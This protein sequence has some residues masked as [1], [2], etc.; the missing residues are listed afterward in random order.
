VKVQIRF[1]HFWPGFEPEKSFF[2]AYVRNREF[3]PILCQKKNRDVDLEIQSVFPGL[4]KRAELKLKNVIRPSVYGVDTSLNRYF[5]HTKYKKH[6]K[7]LIW[8]SGENV[9]T[10]IDDD[11]DLTL[12]YEEDTYGGKNIYFPLWFTS[13]NLM[14]EVIFNARAGIEV[15]KEELMF[16]RTMLDDFKS[17]SFACA[18]IGNPH[19]VRLKAISAISQ[20][21]KVD[22]FGNS[23]GKPIKFKRDVSENY[24]FMFCFENDLYPGY[25][26]EKLID[27]YVSGC[28]PL[29]WG[30]LG[31]NP[32]FNER[33][34]INLKDFPSILDFSEF[35]L[36]LSSDEIAEIYR[37]PLLK[38]LPTLGCLSPLD[39]IL[40]ELRG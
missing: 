3:N 33:S 2:W 28:I 17:R 37:Q 36:G 39:K 24:K 1:S 34:F 25:V 27:A 30:D 20:H 38:A 5:R 15:R 14:S 40:N 8:F 6:S 13:V 9:R 29:Y 7:Y 22:I 31:T 18:F 4:R 35:I 32:F 26:T 23:V 19:P 10:P 16:E 12:S 11:I 21:H